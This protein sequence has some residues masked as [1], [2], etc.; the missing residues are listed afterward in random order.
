[1]GRIFFPGVLHNARCGIEIFLQPGRLILRWQRY[2]TRAKGG[3]H[4][5]AGAKRNVNGLSGV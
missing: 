5:V 3:K 2:L 1:M 4:I